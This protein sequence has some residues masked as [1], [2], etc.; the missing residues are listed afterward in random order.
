MGTVEF[1]G[2]VAKTY[3]GE[4]PD[5]LVFDLDPDES[6]NFTDVAKAGFHLRERLAEI[7]LQTFA[8]L[9]G[10]KGLHVI[11]PLTPEADWA[12]VKSFAG[13]FSRALTQAEPNSFDDT[14]SKVQRTGRSFISWPR[15]R[16][17][18]TG[19]KG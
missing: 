15:H 9:T 17:G 1:Q 14:P 6:L 12:R 18:A 11:A 10:G 16:D 13:R 2:W 7:G 3:G 5:R 4:Q 19:G 8:M